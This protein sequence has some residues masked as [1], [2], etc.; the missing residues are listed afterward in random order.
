MY[1]DTDSPPQRI[2]RERVD[3]L[4][5]HLPEPPWVREQRYRQ[6]GVP[7]SVVHYLIRRGG[8]RLVD[9]VVARAAANLK[10]ACFFFGEKIKGLRRKGVAVDAISDE[11]WCDLFRAMS[12]SPATADAWKMLVTQLARFPNA[13]VHQVISRHAMDRVPDEWQA[14]LASCAATRNPDHAV[15]GL[16]QRHR[17][18]MGVVMR[19]LRG[20]VP[21][22][23]VSRRIFEAMEKQP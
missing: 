12:D 5:A 22:H 10:D 8:A 7:L 16:E 3:R 15:G 20:R 14:R 17:F 9:M 4:A 6:A 1:P 18:L 2:L 19:E 13:S 23:V 11:T 21:A